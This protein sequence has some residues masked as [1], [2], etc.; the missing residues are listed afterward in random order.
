MSDVYYAAFVTNKPDFSRMVG[1]VVMDD[2]QHLDF[3]KR[4][5]LYLTVTDKDT[6]ESYQSPFES[7]TTESGFEPAALFIPEMRKF[8]YKAFKTYD[9]ARGYPPPDYLNQLSALC[10][11]A[12]DI[13]PNTLIYVLVME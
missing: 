5:D 7:V 12:E 3:Q 9:G 2:D 6:G 13:E 4:A 11:K 1:H 8:L 10:D